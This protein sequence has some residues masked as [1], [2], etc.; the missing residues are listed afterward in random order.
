VSADCSAAQDRE[1]ARAEWERAYDDAMAWRDWQTC[2]ILIEEREQA[3][4]YTPDMGCAACQ[5]DPEALDLHVCGR[6]TA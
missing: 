5:G 4:W 6:E 1:K 3:D 2:E